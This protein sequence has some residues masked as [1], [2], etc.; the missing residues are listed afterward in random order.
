[1]IFGEDVSDELVEHLLDGADHEL[2]ATIHNATNKLKKIIN[3]SRQL[4]LALGNSIFI[5]FLRQKVQVNACF[6]LNI[7][8][9]FPAVMFKRVSLDCRFAADDKKSSVLNPKHFLL[10]QTRSNILHNVWDTTISSN[11]L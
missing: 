2:I 5:I 6:L 3:I 9:L 11:S 7:L 10:S 4:K 8:A 1:M